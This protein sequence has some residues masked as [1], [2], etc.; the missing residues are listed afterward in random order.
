M[1][2]RPGEITPSALFYLLRRKRFDDA[3]LEKMLRR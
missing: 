1:P 2:T 3:T